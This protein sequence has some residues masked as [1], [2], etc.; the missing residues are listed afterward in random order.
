[1]DSTEH[2]GLNGGRGQ[3]YLTSR[4]ISFHYN[5]TYHS[6]TLVKE[7]LSGWTVEDLGRE[8]GGGI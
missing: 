5:Q 7:S 8:E 1:M 2:G 3:L 4:S 6:C